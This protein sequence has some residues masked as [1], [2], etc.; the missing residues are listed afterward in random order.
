M[1]GTLLNMGWFIHCLFTKA[2]ILLSRKIWEFPCTSRRIDIHKDQDILALTVWNIVNKLLKI[3]KK[4][5]GWVGKMDTN[6]RYKNCETWLEMWQR[7]QVQHLMLLGLNF[8]TMLSSCWGRMA[9]DV[10][11]ALTKTY[12]KQVTF[13]KTQT[14]HLSVRKRLDVDE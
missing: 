13:A 1:L 9:K 7:N 12:K 10:D 5:P 6:C 8:V 4:L 14:K 11:T 2:R 3:V